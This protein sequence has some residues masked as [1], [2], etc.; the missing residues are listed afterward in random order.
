MGVKVFTVGNKEKLRVFE[1]IFLPKRGELT[2][3]WRSLCNKECH[4]S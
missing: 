2:A 1:R 4:N 3:D